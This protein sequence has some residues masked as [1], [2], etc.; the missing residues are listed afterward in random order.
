M[1]DSPNTPMRRIPE[2]LYEALC[3]YLREHQD[4][5]DGGDGTPLP[6]DAMHLLFQL[7][8]AALSETATPMKFAERCQASEIRECVWVKDT[9]GIYKT[10][11]DHYLAYDAPID[12]CG[13][14]FCQNCGGKVR[15]IE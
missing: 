14:N 5:R 13:V 4:V 10:G 2:D 8:E 12:E 7:S 6:N 9:D 11:C 3:D 15:E 1:A